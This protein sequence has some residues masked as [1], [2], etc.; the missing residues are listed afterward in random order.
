MS[1]ALHSSRG[2]QVKHN[3]S[4]E[5]VDTFEV[6]FALVP[7]VT[8]ISSKPSSVHFREQ[9]AQHH[10]GYQPLT[11]PQTPKVQEHD[12]FQASYWAPF[13]L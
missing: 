9:S 12:R 7:F 1:E 10:P 2:Q 8:R 3:R 13:Q 5:Q 4:Q 11:K 6:I